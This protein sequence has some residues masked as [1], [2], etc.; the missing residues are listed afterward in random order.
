[1]VSNPGSALG[2]AVGKLFET[3]I[4]EGLREEVEARNH[5]IRPAKLTNGSGNSYQIDAV[6]FDAS[7]N[8]VVIIDPK[9]IRYTKH[10]RDKGSWLCVAHY[11]LRK[12]FPTIRKSIAV[13]GGRWSAPSKALIRSFGVEILEVPFDKI[14]N[15]LAGRGIIF[16]WQEKDRATASAAWQIYE[17]LDASDREKI[18]LEMTADILEQLKSDV[19][20]V[21]ETDMNAIPHR[22]SEVEVLLKTDQD[23]MLLLT[24]GSIAD[25]LQAMARM[26]S[27]RP[28]I[29]DLL[30]RQP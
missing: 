23:E 7:D 21:L 6:V 25:T 15:V 16:D 8:P 5:T 1:M 20:L 18:A 26:V 11:N 29:S 30:R 2:E 4:L 9:Y 17:T 10:N 14:V 27:D 3:G 24:F 22:V 13:L 12:T 28:D 19:I